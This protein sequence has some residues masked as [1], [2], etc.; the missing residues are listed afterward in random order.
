MAPYAC[1]VCIL[2]AFFF[3]PGIGAGC[4]CQLNGLIPLNAS[5]QSH[6]PTYRRCSN[7]L[8]GRY[9]TVARRDE[10]P[11]PDSPILCSPLSLSIPPIDAN[12]HTNA[13]P[14]LPK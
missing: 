6:T 8:L 11:N 3:D 13:C 9:L 5:P 12:R 14:H 10:N 7:F 1:G 2:E 4:L